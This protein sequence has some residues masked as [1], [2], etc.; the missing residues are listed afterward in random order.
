[1]SESLR[2]FGY[3]AVFLLAVTGCGNWKFRLAEWYID[4]VTMGSW[5]RPNSTREEFYRENWQCQA[6]TSHI[7][8]E[9]G[10][11]FDLV[12]YSGCMRQHGWTLAPASI[13]L[14]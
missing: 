7:D 11:V 6:Q 3:L 13:K 2:K 8:P 10:M 5:N 12:A 14:R 9:R 4:S 1:M